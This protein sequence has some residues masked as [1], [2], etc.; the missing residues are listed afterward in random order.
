MALDLNFLSPDFEM[1]VCLTISGGSSA[2]GH[3]VE[4]FPGYMSSACNIP[5]LPEGRQSLAVSLLANNELLKAL[6]RVVVSLPV[7]VATVVSG[8][9]GTASGLMEFAY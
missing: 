3:S 2:S 1:P 9:R 5:P 7:P 8:V 6:F 4:V